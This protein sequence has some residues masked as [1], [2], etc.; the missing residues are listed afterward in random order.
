MGGGYIVSEATLRKA[1]G[2]I[3]TFSRECAID[4]FN[5]P[6]PSALSIALTDMKWRFVDSFIQSDT[7]LTDNNFQ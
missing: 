4:L 1:A 5:I 7:Q 3:E 2:M 6:A